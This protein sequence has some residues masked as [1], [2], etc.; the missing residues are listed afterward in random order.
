VVA[1]LP[2]VGLLSLRNAGFNGQ[3]KYVKLGVLSLTMFLVCLYGIEQEGLKV[4][5]KGLLYFQ[6]AQLLPNHHGP[7][8]LKRRLR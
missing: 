5:Q 8:S 1:V 4:E 2:D 6:G 7:K 3:S